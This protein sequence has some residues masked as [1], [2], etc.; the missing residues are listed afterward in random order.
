[1]LTAINIIESKEI[2]KIIEK[3][4]AEI[5]IDNFINSCVIVTEWEETLIE[6]INSEEHWKLAELLIKKIKVHYE[7]RKYNNEQI[8]SLLYQVELSLAVHNKNFEELEKIKYQYENTR[9]N[10]EYNFVDMKQY[11]IAL[12]FIKNDKNYDKAIDLLKA[13]SSKYEN[14]VRYSLLLY[15]ARFLKCFESEETDLTEDDREE[16]NIAWQEWQKFEEKI[17]NEK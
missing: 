16:I 8:T 15:K 2:K 10:H 1:M 3:C 5:N 13:L 17:D 11:F 4:I 9:H 6:A 7:K 14:D 12:Y